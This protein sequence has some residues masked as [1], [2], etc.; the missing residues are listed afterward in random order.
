MSFENGD[1]TRFF[2]AVGYAAACETLLTPGIDLSFAELMKSMVKSLYPFQFKGKGPGIGKEMRRG[3]SHMWGRFFARAYLEG[4]EDVSYLTPIAKK[5]A[6]FPEFE[7]QVHPN[8]ETKDLPDW[9]GW[10]PRANEP[11]FAEAKGSYDIRCWSTPHFT[12]PNPIE[13]A[14]AQI[15]YGEIYDLQTSLVYGGIK[16]WAVATQWCSEKPSLNGK[17]IAVDPVDQTSSTES[18]SEDAKSRFRRAILR[19]Q[20]VLI[21]AKLGLDVN[22]LR[23]GVSSETIEVDGNLMPPG[24]HLGVFMGGIR[25]RVGSIITTGQS[26]VDTPMAVLSIEDERLRGS[27]GEGQFS[28]DRLIEGRRY[29]RSGIQY[30]ITD[31]GSAFLES[32]LSDFV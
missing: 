20:T 3:F 12:I 25:G 30:T 8:S 23:D 7:F 4:S 21:A 2:K 1:S 24:L 10:A 5:N 14:L 22:Q 9:V 16:G 13:R 31:S 11:I 17:L 15:K 26:I 28:T 29:R 32:L 6:A 19:H 27:I 18:M